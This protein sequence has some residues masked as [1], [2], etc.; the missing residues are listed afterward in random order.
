LDA[1]LPDETQAPKSRPRVPI[2]VLA[3]SFLVVGLGVVWALW[4]ARHLPGGRA[5]GLAGQGGSWPQTPWRNARPGVKYVGDTAC[6]RCHADIAETFRRHPM[7]RSLAPISSAP[8]VGFN[9]PYGLTTFG[10]GSSR[11]TILRRGGREVH[12]ETWRDEKG[13]VLARVEAEVK[14]ALGSGTRGVS[15]LVEHDGR[16]FQSPISWYSQKHQ[17]DLSP[18]YEQKNVHFDRPIEPSCL[19]CHANRALPVD[20]SVNQYEEPVFLG[21]AIGCERCHGPGELHVKGQKV[22]DGRDLTIVNPRHLEPALRADVCEQCHLLGDQRIDRLGRRP[23]DY[24]PGLPLTAFFAVYGRVH[25]K[26]HK[27]VGH[28]EQMRVSRCF[29]QSQGRLGC[30]SCHDPHQVPE[31]EEKTAYFREQCLACHEQSGCS[32]PDAERL[33]QSRDD[34]CIQCHMPRSTSVDIVHTATTDHRIRR[35]PEAPATEL[36][37]AA[38]GLPLVLLNGDKTGPEELESLQREL[39]IALTCDG[40]RLP[41]SP[42]VRRMGTLVLSLLDK[43]VAERPED[44]VARRMKAQVLALTGHRSDALPI[45]E[46]VLRSAPSYEKALDECLSYAIDLGDIQAALAPARQAVALNPWSAAFHER[47]A[48]VCL[49]CEDWNGAL[50]ESREALRLDPFL[51]FA[52]MFEVQCLLHQKDWK[53]AETE[54]PKLLKLNPSLRETLEQWYAEQRRRYKT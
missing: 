41:D 49:E 31:P 4:Q 48:F 27:A 30:T 9:R 45:V 50:H 20:L 36:D 7:G 51:R 23:F 43:A 18:G 29:R 10:A 22:V 17:W 11:Y 35:T 1:Q 39:A 2:F 47:L 12:R 13:Q 32:L 44:L 38:G 28:V 42:Q 16:L 6:A 19:F 24:R 53:A 52:R 14:Y 40:P 5:A 26:D 8:A 3:C 33:A 25:E 46:S 34:N 54:F 21:H 15:Y 37:H